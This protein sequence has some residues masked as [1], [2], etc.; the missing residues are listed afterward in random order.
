MNSLPS[1]TLPNNSANNPM[2]ASQ[3][4]SSANGRH[5]VRRTGHANPGLRIAAQSKEWWAFK[6]ANGRIVLDQMEA[7][8]AT[9]DAKTEVLLLKTLYNKNFG[10]AKSKLRNLLLC[11]TVCLG[12]AASSQVCDPLSTPVRRETFL[13][14]LR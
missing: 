10:A 1:E 6:Q 4:G 9:P 7:T 12:V 11:K 14:R 5:E 8:E 3:R 13:T 2:P